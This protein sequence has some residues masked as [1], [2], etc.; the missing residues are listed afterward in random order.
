MRKIGLIII[1]VITLII[2]RI[3][4]KL[5]SENYSTVDSKDDILLQLNFLETELKENHLDVRMQ[6]IFPEGLVFINA[7]Y[8]LAWCELA[9]SDPADSLLKMKAINE[10]LFAFDNIDAGRAKWSFPEYLNPEY[11]I[12]Y[13]GWRNY[14]LSKIFSIDKDFAN[15]DFYYKKLQNQ[16]DLIVS[17]IDSADTPYLES[18]GS[19]SWPADTY[20]AIASLAIYDRIFGQR[21]NDDITKWLESV[22]TKLDPETKMIPHKVDSKNG[23]SN[24]GARGCS[25]ILMLRMLGEIDA[26]FSNQQYQLFKERFVTKTFG[27]PSIREYPL[28]QRGLGDIDSGPVIFGVGFS[29]TIVGIGTFAMYDDLILS[30]RQY[31]TVHAFGFDRKTKKGKKYLYGM[32]PMADAFIAWGRATELN[33]NKDSVTNNEQFWRLKFKL[34]PGFILLIIWMFYFRKWA[35]RQLKTATNKIYATVENRH[36]T[37]EQYKLNNYRKRID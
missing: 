5:H 20:V 27:L 2:L 37:L 1:I 32:L 33:Y 6:R 12:F 14:L 17:A 8:G 21:Y 28:G 18:Y 13:N 11:G 7:L 36:G 15:S 3:N 29:A 19:Q 26:T 31:K 22:K 30:Q 23:N 9:I 16:G 10:A 4:F 34:L 25:M 24:Q 35:W